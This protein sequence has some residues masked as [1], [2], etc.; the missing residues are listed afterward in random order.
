ML[1]ARVRCYIKDNIKVPR[2]YFIYIQ[3]PSLILGYFINNVTLRK[4]HSTQLIEDYFFLK[5]KKSKYF[6]TQFIFLG[7]GIKILFNIFMLAELV[8]FQLIILPYIYIVQ[9][10]IL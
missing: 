9:K 3:N 8:Q 7:Q 2:Q 6:H 1:G 5:M 10:L 4:I